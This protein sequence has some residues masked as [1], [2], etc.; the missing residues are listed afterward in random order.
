MTEY[1][2]YSQRFIYIPQAL[3]ANIMSLYKSITISVKYTTRVIC[4][5]SRRDSSR[6]Y[7]KVCGNAC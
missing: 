2:I 5:A 7:G 3:Y 4:K 6:K 1:S